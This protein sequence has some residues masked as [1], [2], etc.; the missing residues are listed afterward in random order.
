MSALNW[1]SNLKLTLGQGNPTRT[2]SDNLEEIDICSML[3][4]GR[5]IQ[6]NMLRFFRIGD[7]A[8]L[9]A[10]KT[11]IKLKAWNHETVLE[12]KAGCVC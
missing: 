1:V 12:D 2:L 6:I 8:N 7:L 10:W 9:A 5:R 4:G 11:Y 3:L